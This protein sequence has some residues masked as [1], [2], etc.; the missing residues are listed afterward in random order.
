MPDNRFEEKIYL[1]LSGE[2]NRAEKEQFENRINIDPLLKQ[3]YENI[4]DFLENT[5]PDKK[6]ELGEETFER[7]IKKA[8]GKKSFLEK[9][10]HFIEIFLKDSEPSSSFS[11]RLALG[12]G[13]TIAAIAL[14]I[15]FSQPGSIEK[16][17]QNI[18]DWEGDAVTEKI[19]TVEDKFNAIEIEDYK[20][21]VVKQVSEDD[22]IYTV[23]EISNKISKLKRELNEET[24]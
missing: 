6:F 10:S 21:F 13:L 12:G 1:Y 3:E 18:F 19:E 11:F 23:N 22:W 20:D 24:L 8:A 9:F 16:D 7:M 2:L 5:K 4:R 14:L 17:F 15:I